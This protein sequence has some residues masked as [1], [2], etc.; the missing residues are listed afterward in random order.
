MRGVLPQYSWRRLS[1]AGRNMAKELVAEKRFVA[2]SDG[3][4]IDYEVLGAGAPMLLLHGGFA[5]RSTFSSAANSCGA[6]S[7]NYSEFQRTRRD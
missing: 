5:G 6:L 4:K 7:T 2:A 3:V 1:S